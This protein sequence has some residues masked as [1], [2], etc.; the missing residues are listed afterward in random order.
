MK[1]PGRIR[2]LLLVEDDP[3]D[4][5]ITQRALE[6]RLDLRVVVAR[7]GDE[8]MAFLR[9][10]GSFAQAE[11]PDLVLLDLNI[12]RRSGHQVLREIRRDPV[13]TNLPVV[14]FTTSCAQEDI[15]ASYQER[16]NSYVVK[17]DE[18]SDFDRAI[19]IFQTFW[20]DVAA[21]PS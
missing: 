4:V 5:L 2:T 13:L 1:T 6:R 11:R 12:P 21:V 17:P 19:R 10:Q 3:D 16:A 7:D 15:N 18:L 8:A 14:V 20:L 9:R